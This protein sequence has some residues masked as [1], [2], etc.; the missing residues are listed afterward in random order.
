M[1]V[2]VSVVTNAAP[3][4]S[5]AA[6]DAPAT[7]F[8]PCLAERGDT[9]NAI[10]CRSFD[11]FTTLLGD[12]VTYGAGYDSAACYFGEAAG[13]GARIYVARV[14][15]PAATKGTLTLKDRAVGAPL[16]TIRVD[17]SSEGAW[18]GDLTVEVQDGVIDSTFTVILTLNGAEVERYSNLDS[19]AALVRAAASSTYVTVTDLGSATAAPGNNPAVIAATPLSAGSDDRANVGQTELLAALDRFVAE[20]GPGIV[21]IPGQDESIAATLGAH[22]AANRRIGVVA[23]AAGTS[24]SSAQSIARGLRATANGQYLGLVY[25]WVQIPDGAGGVRTVDPAGYVAGVRARTIGRAGTWCAPAGDIAASRFVTGVETPL[26]AAQVS[27]LADDAVNPIRA[28]LGS[29][30][31]YGWRSLSAD[32]VDWRF[33]TAADV[34]NTVAWD[35][36]QALEPYVFETIDGRGLLFTR[37]ANELVGILQPI[38]AAGGLYARTEDPQDPG[39]KVDTGPSV[40]TDATI[41]QG[42]IRANISLRISPVGQLIQITLTKVTQSAQF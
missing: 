2:G 34:L 20:L 42:Q 36:E 12:R 32:E 23:P 5:S 17:A 37:V 40:N 28:M 7:Y 11:E 1:P 22:C 15:G 24:E 19:P 13:A 41:A 29:V 8:M 27:S 33:L 39:Y 3:V 26:T 14:V 31:L 18:S 30:R 35:A 6:A 16:D 9:A 10:L 21:A 4:P 38:A 25:P